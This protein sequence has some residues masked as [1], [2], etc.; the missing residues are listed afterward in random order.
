MGEKMKF[1][2]MFLTLTVTAAVAFADPAPITSSSDIGLA[3]SLVLSDTP[4]GS[5]QMGVGG[6]EFA[7]TVN[8]YSTL[9]WCVDD[10]EEFTFGDSG[11]GNVTLLSNVA[12]NSS[13]VK[14]GN[15]TNGGTPGWTNT[16][17]T[18]DSVALPGTATSRF[19]MAAYLVSQYNGFVG[20]ESGAVVS[21]TA[22]DLAIQEAI[23]SLT[24]NSSLSG[25]FST[26]SGNDTVNT[27]DQYW[28]HQALLNYASINTADWAVVSW[29]TDSLGNLNYQSDKQ[30]FLVQVTPTPEPRFYGV[31]ILAMAG[32]GF[33]A[34]R[35]QLVTK[36]VSSQT[37]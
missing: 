14:Y 1:N 20:N 24:N 27:T 7:G 12:A 15:V 28:I 37:A 8:G 6:G 4:A 22:Q 25:G 26:I 11:Y 23:W 16:T 36:R 3:R 9:Y 30:T 10:Q 34:R 13:S 21:N 5:S 18:F 31:L 29:T 2:L 19:E 35:R 32:L 17:D 33:F